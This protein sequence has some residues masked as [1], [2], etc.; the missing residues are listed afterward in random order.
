MKR[1]AWL[2]I[3]KYI[4]LMDEGYKSY[5]YLTDDDSIELVISCLC[6]QVRITMRRL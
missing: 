1:I 2:D 3:A 6:L 4:C 5:Y